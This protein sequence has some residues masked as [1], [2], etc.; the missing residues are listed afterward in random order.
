MTKRD[1]SP[2]QLRLRLPSESPAQ[3]DSASREKTVQLLAQL[4]ASAVVDAPAPSGREEDDE[5]H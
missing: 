4:L 1:P 5:T 3:F 2:P